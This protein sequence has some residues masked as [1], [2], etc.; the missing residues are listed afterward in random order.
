MRNFVSF[1]VGTV[2]LGVAAASVSEEGRATL[3]WLDVADISASCGDRCVAKLWTYLD[4]LVQLLGWA[5]Y[6]V[7]VEKQPSKA[8]SLMRTVELGI[9]HYFLMRAHRGLESVAVKSV[10]PRRKLAAPVV[11]A[12]G[13]S[14]GQKYKAR[15]NAGIAEAVDA[16]AELPEVCDFLRTGKGDDAADAAL[17]LVHFGGARQFV[18]MSEQALRNG[19]RKAAAKKADVDAKAAAKQA[20]RDAKSAAKQAER[21][22][23]SAAKQAERDAKQAERD[24][25][26]AERAAKQAERDAKQAERDANAAAKQAAR[27]ARWRQ[28]VIL[29]EP[30]QDAP[31]EPVVMPENASVSEST[32]A[33]RTAGGS[34]A[35]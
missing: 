17:Y 27:D 26:Q 30:E 15:K 16:F 32:D 5:R 19:R 28:F 9:R 22:A 2:H 10:S 23:K 6:T 14:S 34:S 29:T 18:G 11:Y 35:E 25:K 7:Y 21:D 24:A 31:A 13:S 20:E 4:E 3:E 12:A 33:D 8:C 1:D